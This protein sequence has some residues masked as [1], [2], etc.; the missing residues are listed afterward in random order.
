MFTSVKSIYD[1]VIKNDPYKLSDINCTSFSRLLLYKQLNNNIDQPN[2][3]SV[4]IC[5]HPNIYGVIRQINFVA[6]NINILIMSEY[7][8]SI[9]KMLFLYLFPNS[10]WELPLSI[11]EI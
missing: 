11:L 1:T 6:Q 7:E 5:F 10:P 2:I 4:I 8:K 3:F 9:N